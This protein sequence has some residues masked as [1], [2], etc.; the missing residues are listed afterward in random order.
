MDPRTSK[1]WVSATKTRNYRIGDPLLD[2][3]KLYGEARGFVPDTKRDGY[4]ART[5]F[6][7]FIMRKGQE[8]EAALYE[9][10]KRVL[11]GLHV[12]R[13]DRSRSIED[14]VADTL[15]L[16]KDG[17]PAIAQ[18]CVAHEASRT[19]G[20]PDLLVRSDVLTRLFPEDFPLDAST[21]S[22]PAIGLV[23]K[24][25]VVVDIKFTS[26]KMSAKRKALT[27]SGS[28]PAYCSQLFIYNRALGEMQGY[29]A[30]EAFLMGRCWVQKSGGDQ[31]RGDSALERI[32][33]VPMLAAPKKGESLEE[34]TNDAIDWY[35][36]VKAQGHRWAVLPRPSVR[37]LYPNM[38][39]T[40]DEPWNLAKREIAHALGE[41]S[42]LWQVSAVKRDAALDAGLTSWRDVVSA[43]QVGVRG[44][45]YG[46]VLDA[47]LE[48]NGSR[49]TAPVMPPIVEASAD[50][51]GVP[52]QVEFYVDFETVNDL[53]DDFSALPRKNGA[54]LIFMIG[55]GHI[56]NGEWKFAE[57]T[58]E[59]I[60]ETSESEIIAQ[61]G[62]HMRDVTQR[63]G[64]VEAPLVIHWSPAEVSMLS[65]A[66]NSARARHPEAA[67]P[68][69]NWFDFLT[70][71]IKKDPVV[72][73]GSLGFGLKSVAKALYRHG[74]IETCWAD[75]PTDGLGAM[76]AAWWADGETKSNGGAFRDL[77][78]IREVAAYNEVDCKVMCEIVEYLRA[79]HRPHTVGNV[80][81]D[82]VERP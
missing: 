74:L 56:E 68:A 51:W 28:M 13:E 7:R 19:Y 73:N 61:W 72:V 44:K 77:E 16:M 67:W 11:P 66:Y 81:T 15:V 29:E 53:D 49:S 59:H 57:F 18:G 14:N 79:H 70:E 62:N 76:V 22:A 35:R 82:A 52:Q 4:D 3:L 75:G 26:L 43:D 80:T 55:C 42:L 40:Q 63:L 38:G 34:V 65:S 45:T 24:H 60:S 47:I 27:S 6:A 41:L 48:V 36:Q 39:N 54:P 1:P 37:E 31:G 78:L 20:Y 10:L 30:A 58:V 9:V 50:V 21:A 46:P 17:V 23:G 5:D 33:A 32:A 71:V 2:W 12:L 8:F 69:V 64:A 25:Y